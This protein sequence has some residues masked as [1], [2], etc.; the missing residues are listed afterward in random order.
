MRSYGI[1]Q[2]FLISKASCYCIMSHDGYSGFCTIG[3][4]YFIWD[5]VLKLTWN[6]LNSAKMYASC[7]FWLSKGENCPVETLYVCPTL[8]HLVQGQQVGQ[9]QTI[10]RQV[11]S[12]E[13]KNETNPEFSLNI[14]SA[15]LAGENLWITKSEVRRPG[16]FGVD[17]G[18]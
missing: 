17:W 11:L 3:L 2:V 14:D 12:L 10:Q 6:P 16:S 4:H 18:A 8:G 9:P 13:C 1:F 15:K 7:D 5:I